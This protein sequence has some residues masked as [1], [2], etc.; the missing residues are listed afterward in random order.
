[1]AQPTTL[2]LQA[3]ST[4]A[5]Y[6]NPVAEGMNV[7]SDTQSWFG[8]VAEKSR[9]TRSGA[10]RASWSRRVVTGPPRRWLAPTSPATRMSRSTRLRLCLS[11]PAR[12]AACTRGAP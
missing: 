11:P 7:M 8:P 4:T 5:R 12:K 3:S 1:M 2:R 9:S 10:G 6:R